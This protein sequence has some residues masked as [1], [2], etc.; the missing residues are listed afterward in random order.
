MT[1]ETKIDKTVEGMRISKTI[2]RTVW[3]LVFIIPKG[4]TVIAQSNPSTLFTQF[5][6]DKTKSRLPDFSF[7]GY[8]YGEKAIGDS[9][10]KIFNI[11]DFGAIPDDGQ[12]DKAAIEA[13]ISAAEANGSGVVFFPK[14]RFLVH[15]RT[16]NHTSILIGKSNIVLRGS[17]SG[18]DGTLLVMTENLVP[19]DTTQKWTTPPM[20]MVEGKGIGASIGFIAKQAKKGDF[21]IQLE[22]NVSVKSGDWITLRME[23]NDPELIKQ[24]LGG[25]ALDTAWSKLAKRGVFFQVFVEVKACKGNLLQLHAPIAFDIDPKHRW[26]VL[27][28]DPITEVGIEDIAFIGKWKKSFVHHRSWIDDSAWNILSLN[29]VSHSWISNCRF[30]DINMAASVGKGANVSFLN[31]SVTGNGGHE[32]IRNE[33]GTNIFLGGLKDE[34]SSFHAF[35]VSGPSMNTVIW[36]CSYPSTTSFEIHSSQPRNTLLDL[37]EGGLLINRGGGALFNMPNHLRNLVLWNYKQTNEPYVNFKFWS[38]V[39]WYWKVP[40]VVLV[41]YHGSPTTFDETQLSWKESIGTK[42][43]PESLYEEQLKLRLGKIPGWLNS[44]KTDLVSQHN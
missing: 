25:H 9:K 22:R 15:E 17:G 7:A 27:Y 5:K 30:T 33:G 28:F 41:G 39:K 21:N 6:D 40:D 1:R 26:E 16:D 13:A 43:T 44:Y 42:V 32:S 31:C 3:I 38:D 35:G 10:H 23:N 37:V 20:F 18:E 19:K 34:A 8:K 36:R 29:N 11:V 2:F 12:S 4:I 24:D 14:G